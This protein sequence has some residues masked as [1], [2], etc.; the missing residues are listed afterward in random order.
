MDE[1][2]FFDFKQNPSTLFEKKEDVGEIKPLISIISAYYNVQDYIMETAR[3]LFNQTFPFW[4]WIIVDDCSKE[5]NKKILDELKAMD[6]RIKVYYN[7]KNMKLPKTRDVAISKATTDYIYV[8]DPDD[9]VDKTALETSYFAMKTH[10]DVT[11][12]CSDSV[13]FGDEEYVWRQPFNMRKEKKENSLCVNAL[14]KKQAVLD[15]GGYSNVPPDVYEDWHLWLRLLENGGKLL[16]MSYLAFWY[17]RRNNGVL[18]GINSDKKKKE[19][20]LKEI[21]RIGKK[22]SDDADVA[23]QYP[24]SDRYKPYGCHP[25]EFDFET[26]YIKKEKNKKRILCIFPWLILGGADKYNLNLLEKLKAEGYEVTIVTTVAS[27]YV[28]RQK[29]EKYAKEI[30]DLTTFLDKKDWPAFIDYLIKSRN[31]DLIFQSNSEYGYYVIPW[32]KCRYPDIPIIDYV[33]MEEWH[34]RDGGYPR[35]SIAIEKYLDYTYTCSAYLIDIMK[36][37]MNKQKD[38]IDVVYIGTD[39]KSFN[40]E[41]VQEPTDKELEKLKDKK[42][43][44]FTCRI[45][46]QKRPVLMIEI[47][48]KL[49]KVR[50]DIGFVV[51]GDGNM[52]EP[53]KELAETYGIL[54]NIAFLGQKKDVRPYYKIADVTLICSMIEGLSLT[55]YESLVMGVPIV[56]ADVGG[57]KELIDESCGRIIKL[58]QDPKKNINT[59]NYSDEEIDEYVNAIIDVIE[60]G[61]ELRK[62]CRSK[63]LEKF[64]IEKMQENMLDIIQKRIEK[65]TDIKPEDIK[66]DYN[67]AE[68]L[69]VM[70]NEINRSKYEDAQLA[71]MSKKEKFA[72]KMWKYKSYRNFIRFMKKFK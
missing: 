12:V 71:Y 26:P 56:S 20:A 11:W 63:I 3:S 22:I 24:L 57:Q 16:K 21:A 40:P 46:E 25:A 30:F 45:A 66:N 6:S 5:E 72:A 58:Y 67:L 18:S 14:I 61:D 51:V 32:L 54:D 28:W 2:K 4:E 41:I 59:Y 38:N 17:R 29:F 7:E 42:K 9:M 31:Y 15:V 23:I 13:G 34:W 1:K 69:I 37:K 10:P 39:E 60:K 49:V 55:S 70:H 50:N 43:V 33:H 47:L 68:R 19:I 64:T 53:I 48:R 65:G 36:E 8:L 52:L 44:L 27:K 62:N 35:D